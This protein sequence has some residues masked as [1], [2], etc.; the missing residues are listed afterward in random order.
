MNNLLNI[1]LKLRD[2]GHNVCFEITRFGYVVVTEYYN[3]LRS[4]GHIIYGLGKNVLFNA[5][6]NS[7]PTIT[8]DD[9]KSRLKATHYVD[10][11]WLYIPSDDSKE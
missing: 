4:D 10:S 3:E 1:I 11:C 7:L 5:D 2:E 6:M 8:E 9:I